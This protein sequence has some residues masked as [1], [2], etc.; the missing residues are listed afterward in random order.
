MKE[1]KLNLFLLI[2]LIVGTI[3]GGGIFNSPTDLIL[4]ANPL[5][6]FIAWL[7]GGVGI[8]MLALVFYKLT[9]VKPDLNGGI[10][11]YAKEGFGNYV[12]FNSFW[13]YWLGAIFGNIAFISLFFKTLNSMLPYPLSPLGC[14]IGGSI[15]LWVY[16]WIG[17]RGVRKVSILNAVITITKVLPLILVII[18]GIVLFQ[19]H[20]FSVPQWSHVLVSTGRPESLSHQI[21]QAMST[22]VW[23]FVGIEAA[24]SMSRRAKK[25]S[26]V[27][28]A[29]VISF[30]IVWC[31]YVLVSLLPM[32]IIPAHEL[33]T[34]SVPL[35]TVL[36]K[37]VIGI[38]GALIIKVGL[39]IS[40]L[41]ALLSWFMIGPEI[42]YV[43][44]MDGAMPK[45]FREVNRHNVPGFA[46][47]VYTLIMQVI[48]IVLLLPQLQ[49]AY[50]IAY[51]LATTTT[52][53]AYLLSSLY[54]LKLAFKESYSAGFK[55]V[56]LVASAYAIYTLFATG[57]EYAFA[58]AII[59]A[60]GIPV[61]LLAAP[62]MRRFE[63]A[64]A[65]VIG[66]AGILAIVMIIR[67][68]IN[69]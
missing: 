7:I 20:V 6:A 42:A 43:T 23:C 27:G 18:I 37:S 65:L 40:L 17:W 67:G 63:K 66:V 50:T 38:W 56:A 5:A 59:F 16:T 52:L 54:G 64:I 8:L 21:G 57:I 47:I 48:L 25:H 30:V 11:T 10:Y 46:L 51:T 62:K 45:P 22:I 55:L 33:S 68:G 1:K 19:P 24:V 41:G 39:L 35:A 61:Y 32:G 60:L 69:F 12:G 29:T 15:I 4:K 3:I 13:G 2:T 34:S 28:L 49:T 44:S 53:V 58:S 36:S 14:F 9:I 31:L 26:E